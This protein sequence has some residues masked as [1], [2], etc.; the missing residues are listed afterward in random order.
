MVAAA[1]EHAIFILICKNCRPT[2]DD[3]CSIPPCG[4]G[5]ITA[6]VDG[7]ADGATWL[8]GGQ[9]IN[10]L[11]STLGITCSRSENLSAFSCGCWRP[12]VSPF[13]PRRNPPATSAAPRAATGMRPPPGNVLMAP[14][15]LLI[16]FRPTPLPVSS[17]FGAGTSSPIQPRSR[18]IRSLSPPAEPWWPAA[19]RRSPTGL[20]RR[21][22]MSRA[23]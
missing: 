11:D 20:T 19:P 16:F 22:S 17:R 3:S 4:Q 2:K 13:R 15:G 7:S 10:H 14:P 5:E 6:L 18:R 23:P 1:R 12:P 8:G 9:N 21:I